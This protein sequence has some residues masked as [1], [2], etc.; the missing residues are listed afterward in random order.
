MSV[1]TLAT[2]PEAT[3]EEHFG[4]TAPL[5]PAPLADVQ[6]LVLVGTPGSGKSTLASALERCGWLRVSQDEQGK[7][8]CKKMA[9]KNAKLPEGQRRRVVVDRCNATLAERAE[10]LDLVRGVGGGGRIGGGSSSPSGSRP[11]TPTTTLFPASQATTPTTAMAAVHFT[12]AAKTCIARISTRIGHPTLANDGKTNVTAV[13][14][15]FGKRLVT[16]TKS[17]GF[18]G[19]VQRVASLEDM[20]K[21]L[22]ELGCDPTAL[23]VDAPGSPCVPAL[24][25]RSSTVLHKYKRQ[26][27]TKAAPRVPSKAKAKAAT[28]ATS[29]AA[30][31]TPLDGSGA[32]AATAA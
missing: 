13:V 11:T 19:G 26:A 25:G 31:T 17:E 21:L 24:R 12:V 15:G 7:L 23:R 1:W 9:I 8:G 20:T 32:G 6:A 5:A 3:E 4:A 14:K 22:V 30:T 27:T 28:T 10:W 2:I 18:D 16:P 29:A